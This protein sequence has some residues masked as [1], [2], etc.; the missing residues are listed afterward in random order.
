M[1]I[2]LA[3]SLIVLTFAILA[4]SLGSA[5][6][7]ETIAVDQLQASFD[8]LPPGD[9]ARGGQIFVEQS[10]RTCHMDL[11]VGPAFP[12]EPPLAA[13]AETQK[14]GY[15]AELYLYESIVAPRAHVVPGF[16]KDVM[17]AEFG[18]MLTNQEQADLIAYLLTM[19]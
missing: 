16:Q 15:S 2:Q 7:N 4:C 8:K 5:G 6:N 19:K 1:K 12:G 10:C 3:A 17:P 13:R 11:E 18:N 14:T 9:A